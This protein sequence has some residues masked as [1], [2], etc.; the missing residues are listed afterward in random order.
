MGV[1]G[2]VLERRRDGEAF[3]VL[4]ER[5]DVTA[6]GRSAGD[7]DEAELLPEPAG[8]RGVQ[9]AAAEDF[10]QVDIL[11]RDGAARRVDERMVVGVGPDA[12]VGARVVELH[13]DAVA[14]EEE[15]AVSDAALGEQ[16]EQG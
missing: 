4:E 2:L 6:V 11:L 1:V 10:A 5:G 8:A 9:R 7:V 14:T 13:L 12:D 15:A 3:A 16:R